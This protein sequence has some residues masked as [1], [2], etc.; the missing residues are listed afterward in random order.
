M[1]A[2]IEDTE[3]DSGSPESDNENTDIIIEDESIA[4][5]DIEIA[6]H[7][8]VVNVGETISLSLVELHVQL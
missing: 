4:V 8:D 1:G 7:E 5:T 6:D 3:L 2:E